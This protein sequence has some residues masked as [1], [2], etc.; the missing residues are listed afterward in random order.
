MEAEPPFPDT[1]SYTLKNCNLPMRVAFNQKWSVLL[2]RAHWMRPIVEKSNS[3]R[4]N[5][6]EKQNTCGIDRS[7]FV[8][9][10]GSLLAARTERT[11]TRPQRLRLRRPAEI[12][13]GTRSPSGRVYAKEWRGLPQRWSQG[14]LPRPR[15]GPR[16]G[17][18]EWYA[19]G[20]ARWHRSAQCKWDLPVE[21]S[22]A[23]AKIGAS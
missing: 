16:Q 2:K 21:P 5:G 8:D 6:Y 15:H 12:A 7:G 10:R 23:N 20:A 1:Y 19:A 9:G 13:G 3:R 4:K 17:R 18:W 22:R 14:K 11:R